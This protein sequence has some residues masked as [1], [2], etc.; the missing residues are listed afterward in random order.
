MSRPLILFGAFD[1]HNFGDLLLARCAAARHPGRR[2]LAAGLAARDLRRY[3][4]HRVRP[5][6]E[7]VR[8]FGGQAADFVHVGGEIL[9]TTAW[10]AAVMLQTP[11]EAAR[12]IARFRAD[13][14]A[15]RDWA[16]RVLGDE[17]PLP[18]VRAAGDLPRAWRVCF[19]AVG[20]VGF[21]QLPDEARAEAVRALRQAA[22]CSVRDAATR[23]ALAG[24][25]LDLPIA[26][27][28][29]EDCAALFGPRVAGRARAGEPARVAAAM[30]RR[31]AVQV[32]A[33]WGDDA[34][35]SGVAQGV[36]ASAAA[37]DA[38]VVLF[39]AGLAPWHDDAGVLARLAAQVR[40]CN[41]R[42]AVTAFRSAHVFDIC[43][44]L[45]GAAGCIGTSLH[46]F[47]VARS[48]RVPAV[49]LVNDGTAKA[50]AYLDTW[51]AE[52]RRWVAREDSA[53]CGELFSS[54][55]AS[56]APA[57]SGD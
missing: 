21:G 4:G 51:H 30:P 41:P 54:A 26:R 5:L 39:R 56:P 7:V 37:L 44:L 46:A 28:P 23:D 20:G 1:R 55:S 6:A 14:A 38:G 15:G 33:E 12:I 19:E 57:P 9:T 52:P 24:A 11:A 35:L 17:A 18:Y 36:A 29:A 49:C 31:L 45:A 43:A 48:F 10:E 2:V 53:R 27:D 8:E 34:T 47:I 22:A 40:D 3:G 32:A 50:A 42:I 25:G 13:P 16:A